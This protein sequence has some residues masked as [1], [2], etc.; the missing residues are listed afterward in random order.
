MVRPPIESLRLPRPPLSEADKEDVSDY[1]HHL[2]VPVSTKSEERRPEGEQQREEKEES[3]A[4]FDTVLVIYL[5]AVSKHKFHAFYKKTMNLLNLL[6]HDTTDLSGHTAIELEHLHSLGINSVANYPPFFSGVASNDRRRFYQKI[7]SENKSEHRQDWRKRREPW[8]W[9]LAEHLGFNT[10]GGTTECYL[11][12][13]EDCYEAFQSYLHYE[14]G[15][16]YKQYLAESANRLPGDFNFPTSAYCESLY[17]PQLA[18][19][20]CSTCARSPIGPE[21]WTGNKLAMSYVYDW[22]RSWLSSSSQAEGRK[23][24]ASIIF[25]ETHQQDFF[26]QFDLE[27]SSFLSDLLMRKTRGKFGTERTAILLLADHGMHF[28]AEYRILMGKIANKQPFAYLI[29]PKDY[30]Q[31][32]ESE[33]EMLRRNAKALTTPYD[34][35]ATVQ[36]W[37]TGRDWSASLMAQQPANNYS[38]QLLNAVF[39]SRF[40]QNLMTSPIDKARSCQAAGIP[41]AYCGCNLFPCPN[42]IKW[43]IKRNAK[44]IVQYMNNVIRESNPAAVAVCKPLKESEV[45]F[46]PA[47]D[48]CLANDD[49]VV[50][51]AWVQRQMRLVSVTFTFEEKGKKLR[52]SNIN[53]VT[54][55]RAV[56]AQCRAKMIARNISATSIPEEYQQFCHC[57]EDQTTL[58]ALAA[59]IHALDIPT[60]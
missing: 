36:Y 48:D 21:E 13:K 54:P 45:M 1:L 6:M 8:L 23:R 30:L 55:Y 58:S 53:T 60:I 22:W 20:G 4:L 31:A 56:W 51:H 35:R 46:T 9:D 37:M 14:V 2:S 12:C 11:M 32:H 49:I 26:E 47:L 44:Q 5:D 41:R 27:V 18:A 39:A 10:L 25:E 28:E 29:L 17:R 52:M 24:F 33:A 3:K 43:L 19:K 7:P 15:G 34:L 42:S 40:G 38:S 57:N 16:F 50:V 59:I